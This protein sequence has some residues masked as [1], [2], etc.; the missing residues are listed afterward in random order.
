MA[1]EALAPAAPHPLVELVV[2]ASTMFYLAEHEHNPAVATPV[3]A[4]HYI[5]TAVSVGYA[6]IFPVTELGKLIGGMV[7]LL[8]PSLSAGLKT[9]ELFQYARP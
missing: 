4:F 8:G 5:A 9:E 6:N 1:D 2:A 7:M 3:D